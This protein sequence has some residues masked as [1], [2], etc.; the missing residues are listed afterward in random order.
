[1][2]RVKFGFV[3]FISCLLVSASTPITAIAGEYIGEF[4]WNFTNTT[5]GSSGVISLGVEHI[6][7]GHYLC[8]GKATVKSPVTLTIPVFGNAE[9]VDGKIVITLTVPG[10]RNGNL[11]SEIVYILLT[12]GFNGTLESIGIYSDKIEVSQGTVT[13]TTCP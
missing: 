6:G 3:L 11:G 7:D 2:K 10:R 8:S 4:C 9:I 1:M 12:S 13:Y 5:N